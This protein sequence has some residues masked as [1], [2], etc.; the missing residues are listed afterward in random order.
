M[1]TT[2]EVRIFIL[3]LSFRLF[4]SSCTKM[5]E[6]TKTLYEAKSES[7]L[8]RVVLVPTQEFAQGAVQRRL[9][10][11]ARENKDSRLARLTISDNWSVGMSSLEESPANDVIGVLFS[12]PAKFNSYP[13]LLGR[14]LIRNSRISIQV[15]NGT[16]IGQDYSMGKSDPQQQPVNGSARLKLISFLVGR[17]GQL[18]N[19]ETDRLTYFFKSETSLPSLDQAQQL[20]IELQRLHSEMRVNLVVRTDS[21]FEYWGGPAFDRFDLPQPNL[22]KNDY[23]RSAFL[24]CSSRADCHKGTLLQ[25]EEGYSR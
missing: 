20:Q 9:L 23:L 1:N 16:Q 25:I 14:V 19:R 18:K 22:N 13:M 2:M 7:V 12:N 24:E 6:V 4:S 8:D 17:A 3:L 15:R 5:P 11:F 10:S 21:E